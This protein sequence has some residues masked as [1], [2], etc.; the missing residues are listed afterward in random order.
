MVHKYRTRLTTG[1]L[2]RKYI[3]YSDFGNSSSDNSS[4]SSS[5]NEDF[6]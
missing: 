3:N 4:D 1:K 5:D 6:S 2:K